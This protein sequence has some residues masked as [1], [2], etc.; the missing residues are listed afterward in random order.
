MMKYKLINSQDGNDSIEFDVRDDQDPA[1]V[2]LEVLGWTLVS[3]VG[4]DDDI[5]EPY[6]L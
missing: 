4:D 5:T 1:D 6:E 3:R 2:A